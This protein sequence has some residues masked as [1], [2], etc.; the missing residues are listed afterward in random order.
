MKTLFNE[1]L[2]DLLILNNCLNA[3][4]SG[5]FTYHHTS[6]VVDDSSLIKELLE[7]EKKNSLF[8][9]RINVCQAL[10]LYDR[11]KKLLGF[12]YTPPT[13]SLTPEGGLIDL[14]HIGDYGDPT[15][16]GINFLDQDDVER[17][18]K[19]T[20]DDDP[21]LAQLKALRVNWDD[22]VVAYDPTG[23]GYYTTARYDTR[24]KTGRDW[25]ALPVV[26]CRLKK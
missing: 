24:L 25:H 8:L 19:N 5:E 22:Q 17:M 14:Y 20:D 12:D 6:I 23:D 2:K 10:A 7:A 13:K 1:I 9:K 11:N 16:N 3:E 18:L 15:G 4:L 26:V 21:E